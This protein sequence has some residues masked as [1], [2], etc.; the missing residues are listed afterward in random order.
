MDEQI[1]TPQRVDPLVTMAMSQ[2]DGSFDESLSPGDDGVSMDDWNQRVDVDGNEIPL[3]DGLIDGL[4]GDVGKHETDHVKE[5]VNDYV[6]TESEIGDAAA[7][8]VF[9]DKDDGAHDER[10]ERGVVNEL[11]LTTGGSDE[12]D[13]L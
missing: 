4:L 5:D 13:E 8:E 3:R 1:K 9:M 12:H 11:H 6:M 10:D 2:K 7:R